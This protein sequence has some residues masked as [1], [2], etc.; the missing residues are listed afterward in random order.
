[1]VLVSLLVVAVAAVHA[2]WRSPA[3]RSGR[4]RAVWLVVLAAPVHLLLVSVVGSLAALLAVI[5]YATRT[6]GGPKDRRPHNCRSAWV[7]A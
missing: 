2:L 6:A 4:E 5:A 1:M 7:V 3:W